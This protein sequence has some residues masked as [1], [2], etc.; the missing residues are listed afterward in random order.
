M[1]TP[2]AWRRSGAEGKIIGTSPLE[3]GLIDRFIS[4]MAFRFAL[5]FL[6]T[7]VNFDRYFETF[8][9]GIKKRNANQ[10]P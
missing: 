7:F 2:T 9:L 8:T 4:S 10:L 6:L 3:M 5:N 1:G